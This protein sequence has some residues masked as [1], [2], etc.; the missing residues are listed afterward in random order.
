MDAGHDVVPVH[1][2]DGA[3][4]GAQGDVQHRA[5]LGDVDPIAPEH[6]LRA[7]AHPGSLGERHQQLEGAALDAVLGVVEV[8]IADVERQ[9]LPARGVALE[10]V[11]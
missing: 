5:V 10:E 1:L 8:Q 2:D 11:A 7:P 4:G 9:L 6:R 3:A